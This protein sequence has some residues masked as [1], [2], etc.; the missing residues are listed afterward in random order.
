MTSYIL[1][2]TNFLIGFTFFS[3]ILFHQHNQTFLH[4]YENSQLTSILKDRKIHEQALCTESPFLV[5]SLI[6]L[7]SKLGV[8]IMQGTPEIKGMDATYTAFQG[9]L[10][11]ITLTNR[12]L[13]PIVYCQLI[14]HEFIH[15]LQHINGR[16]KEVL[17]L[18][19]DLTY[20]QIYSQKSLQ[21]AEAYAYQNF[22]G[23]I[24]FLLKEYRDSY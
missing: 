24:Y 23:K 8:K 15:V 9:R 2:L 19:W 10:G 20:N 16:L 13:S 17:P 3:D 7:G 18:D 4:T 6:I 5:E 11:Y 22:I 12:K 14:T 21:E 1:I